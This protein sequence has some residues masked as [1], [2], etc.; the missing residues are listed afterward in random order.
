MQFDISALFAVGAGVGDIL[1]FLRPGH[2]VA[3]CF[4]FPEETSLVRT[5][6]HSLTDVVHQLKFPTVPTDGGPVFPGRQL[7]TALVI[8]LQGGVA[9]GLAQF[10][11]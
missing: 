1:S 6:L 2:T 9:M 8:G 4:H 7:R 5:A 11:T 10:V 3:P